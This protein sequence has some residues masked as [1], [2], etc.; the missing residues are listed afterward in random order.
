MTIKIKDLDKYYGKS[1]GVVNLN[2][3]VEPGELFGFI[4]PNGAG[5]S[6]TIR[7]LLNMIWPSSGSATIFGLDC[8]RGSQQIKKQTGYLTEE[9]N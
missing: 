5:K 6:T 4:G 2:L 8:T 9:A 1:R 3:Q 7:V